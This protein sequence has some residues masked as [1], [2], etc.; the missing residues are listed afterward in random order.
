MGPKTEELLEKQVH[1]HYMAWHEAFV[2]QFEAIYR[3]RDNTGLDKYRKKQGDKHGED[4][5]FTVLESRT[6]WRLDADE[7]V[8]DRVIMRIL[9]VDK[10]PGAPKDHNTIRLARKHILNG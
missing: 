2:V 9:A 7:I 3:A 10:R 8:S 1:D 5:W 6:A 4:N